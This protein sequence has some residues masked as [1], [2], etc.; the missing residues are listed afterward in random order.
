MAYIQFWDFEGRRSTGFAV[1]VLTVS[2]LWAHFYASIGNKDEIRG[3]TEFWMPFCRLCNY[4]YSFAICAT[5]MGK[6]SCA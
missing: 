2:L 5:L 1:A 3:T 6:N 4:V